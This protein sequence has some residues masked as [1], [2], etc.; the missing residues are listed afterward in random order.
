MIASKASH[1]P[2]RLASLCTWGAPAAQFNSLLESEQSG[3]A[4]M[5]SSLAPEMVLRSKILT[6][7]K[8]GETLLFIALSKIA[9]R[10]LETQSSNVY[11]GV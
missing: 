9:T 2:A 11:N 10:G 4:G 7:A 5:E 8:D 3:T 1:F 6:D